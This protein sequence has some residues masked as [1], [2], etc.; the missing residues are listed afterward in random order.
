MNCFIVLQDAANR[1][2]PVWYT[3]GCFRESTVPCTKPNGKPLRRTV[4]DMLRTAGADERNF[5]PATSKPDV[6]VA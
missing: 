2:Q 1:Q 4:R 5:F 6:M 3:Q